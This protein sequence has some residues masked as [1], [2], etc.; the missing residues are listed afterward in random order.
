M[1]RLPKEIRLQMVLEKSHAIAR[2]GQTVRLRRVAAGFHEASGYQRS[3]DA[4]G[5]QTVR[6]RRV[7]RDVQG[8]VQLES[9]YGHPFGGETLQM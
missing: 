9:A 6:M 8:E 1:Q 2:I 7:P 4:H 3:D 5:G